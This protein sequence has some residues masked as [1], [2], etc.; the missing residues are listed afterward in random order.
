MTRVEKDA[1][2]LREVPDGMTWGIHT[3]RASE[4]FP[5]VLGP[6][7]PAL[8]R[9]YI[10]VKRACAR[11]NAE[12]GY[13][14]G[15]RARAIEAA[16]VRWL[17]D[18]TAGVCPLDA[19]QGGAGTSLNL[20]VNEVIANLALEAMG[21]PR[22]DYAAL[23]PF[24]HVNLHQSTNDTYPTA[25][26]IAALEALRELG[27]RCAG[28]QGALQRREKALAGVIIPA[29]T[30][31]MDAVPITL[32]AQFGSFAEAVARDRWRTVKCTER[33]RL[34]NLGGTA[35]GTGLAAPRDYIFRVVEQLRAETGLGLARAE[36]L[37]DQTANADAFVEVSG[38]LN[39]CA[40]NLIKI[41]DDLR[42]LSQREFI[43]L[44][45]LQAGSSIMPGKINPVMLEYAIQGGMKVRANDGLVAECA[46][47]GSLQICEFL[48]LLGH[49]LLES[50]SI[51][52]AVAG[53]MAAHVEGIAA[54][55][56]RCRWALDRSV[57][58]FAVWVAEVG[59]AQ[60]G[61]W[62][63]D[64]AAQGGEETVRGFLERQLGVERVARA[65]TPERVTALGYT[66]ETGEGGRRE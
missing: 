51:L 58:L 9:A 38:I 53:R 41:A 10:R 26:K 24:D 28:L 19:L 7:A 44:P 64:Y 14:A 61:A 65:L 47:R 50:L 5:P 39:A 23:D 34:I 16:C 4:N 33:L 30:E 66:A 54:R 25:L 63:A 40:S 27:D 43:R 48:P 17:Q 3:L 13:L 35:V 37:M 52:S 56:E 49:A 62:A 8:I 57:G 12:L 45:P 32:G 36:N 59:Y 31:R 20:F 21:R 60:A 55:P 42:L 11:T 46:S 1:L 29:G 18:P 6:V 22:G 2:G 15:D